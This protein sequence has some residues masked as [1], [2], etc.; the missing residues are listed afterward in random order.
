MVRDCQVWKV[1]TDHSSHTLNTISS[2]LTGILPN[3]RD[4]CS[5]S[6]SYSLIAAVNEKKEISSADMSRS[7]AHIGCSLTCSQRSQ[8]QDRGSCQFSCSE[9]YSLDETACLPAKHL[10]LHVLIL[11]AMLQLFSCLA[12]QLVGL[13]QIMTTL[14]SLCMSSK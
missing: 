7:N 11:E 2:V 13:Y 6:S 14:L 9:G 1:D 3:F 12:V 5:H 8:H 10:S 4:R